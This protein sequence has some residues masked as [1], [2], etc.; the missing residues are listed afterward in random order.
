MQRLLISFN[1]LEALKASVLPFTTWLEEAEE[2]GGDSE[3]DDDDKMAGLAALEWMELFAYLLL[4]F[5]AY[6]AC[7]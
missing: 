5:C 7:L 2:G 6:R 4:L 1:T 3:D